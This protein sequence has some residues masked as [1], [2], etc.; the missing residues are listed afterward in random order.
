MRDCHVRCFLMRDCHVRS[1]PDGSR[2]EETEVGLRR[3]DA[4]SEAGDEGVG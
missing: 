1:S 2:D 3:D 4:L